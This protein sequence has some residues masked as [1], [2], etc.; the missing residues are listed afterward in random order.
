MLRAKLFLFSF[1][2]AKGKF[3]I[4]ICLAVFAQSCRPTKHLKDDERLL[5]KVKVK[6]ENKA[7]FK[8]ELFTL[9]KQ[10]PNRKL[11]GVFRLYLG[12]YNLYYNKPD[13]RMRNNVGEAPVIY[14]S[15][16]NDASAKQMEKYLRNRGYYESEV[17]W[18]A[19]LKKKKAILKYKVAARDL[20][21]MK[22]VS[23]EIEDERIASI[24][25]SNLNKTHIKKGAPF[26]LELMNK[27]RKRI[28]KDLK[29][30]G[31]FN[32]TKEF[33]QFAADTNMVQKTGNIT[34]R[35]I[36]RK[37]RDRSNETISEKPHLIYQIN[38]VYVR[39]ENQQ[40][41]DLESQSDTS[42]VD[43]IFFIGNSSDKVRR[44]VLAKL[45]YLRP[46]DMF[47]QD[48]QELTYRNLSG[49]RLFSFVSIN[50]EE[51]YVNGNNG[52]IAYID[53][54]FRK[55]KSYTLETEGTNNG[56][57]FGING[58]IGF[59]NNNTFRGAE[60][61]NIRMTGAIEA[62]QILTEQNDQQVIDGVLPFNTYEFGPEVNLEVPRFLLPF[63]GN[64]VSQKG[65]PRTN[66]NISYNFQ[67]RPDYS[68]SVSKSYISYSWNETPT[69]THII[70]PIDFSF[71]KLNKTREFE[72]LLSNIRN[73][74][75]RNSYTDN[76][77]LAAKYSF[78]L[79]TQSSNKL[80]DNFY[81]RY[82][83]ETAGNLISLFTDNLIQKN[84]SEDF[85]EIGG[86][87]FAQYIRSDLDFRFYQN[88]EYNQI[89]Y[90]LAT[91]IGI[92]YGNS[93]AMPFEKSFY[94]GGAN[95]IRAWQA[96]QLGPGNLPDSSTSTV[97]QI[98]NLS[99]EGN[100]EHRF[101]ITKVVEGAAFVDA[102]NIWN[103]DQEDSREST[104]FELD[105]VWKGTALGVGFGIRL[106]FNFF[107]FRLDLAVPVK[108]P[109]EE[110]PTMIKAQYNNSNLNF[111]I[112]Y[113]F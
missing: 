72:N 21:R 61:L 110:N 17:S 3:L 105:K 33:V 67:N 108:D 95:G 98:G 18:K 54:N 96:R 59:Q 23:A 39:F 6:Y 107:I 46:G 81:F 104:Q 7:V 112:G 49:L 63:Y 70:Q 92:P 38:R 1:C 12:I 103:Y 27:E 62:Q 32:F 4:L 84:E 97:D 28:E 74:F 76:L 58:N 48:L 36:N 69:K 19:K 5:T 83:I 34:T 47:R 30:K 66:F 87:R 75:L 40:K 10:K 91:G 37:I 9:S 86:V 29:N 111:G 8:D 94:A 93:V 60:I 55:Q 106:N 88:Y 89:A 90:R 79:N 31:Y 35:I 80:K 14:D 77:I 42:Q 22:E 53:L 78:I 11:L 25:Q 68:R 15:T 113:P 2:N 99:I 82:N 56:G 101:K 71:I 57:N 51:D 44:D 43:S 100:V 16:L 64:K 45:I 13:S 65:N 52:L 26:D 50:Y 109:A 73:P 41:K 20:Y 102:G 24:Y 85:Y